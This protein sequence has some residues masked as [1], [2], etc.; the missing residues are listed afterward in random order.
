[1]TDE[2]YSLAHI[3]GLLGKSD[4]G[5]IQLQMILAQNH[6]DQLSA[7]EAAID[8]AATEMVKNRHVKLGHSEDALSIDLVT[9]LKAMGFQASHDTQYGGHCDI[10]VEAKGQF[11]WIAECKIH[12]DYGWLAKGFA[13]LDTRYSTG[14]PGQDAGE[15]IIYS[16]IQRADQG[17]ATWK[18][19][20]KAARPDVE[21]VEG[22]AKLM[23][24]T[25]HMHELTGTTFR[26]RHICIPLYFKPADRDL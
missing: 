9:S 23:F 6:G 4:A 22:D 21:F 25:T 26:V 12:G 15:M 1:M 5:H 16:R 11:L 24:R 10:V 18:E 3:Y 8:W 13:Q 17:M 14:L 19:R 7:V 20:L 2:R